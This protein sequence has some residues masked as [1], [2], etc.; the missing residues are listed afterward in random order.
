M[1][2]TIGRLADQV[3]G[4][5]VGQSDLI[6]TGARSLEQ[7]GPGDISFVENE[8]H[9]GRLAH[10]RASAVVVSPDLYVG[11]RTAIRVADPLTAFVQIAQGFLPRFN[12]P[13]GIDPRAFVHPS[14]QVHA[15]STI[16]AF[17]SIGPNAVIGK[18]CV[19]H[20]GVSVGAHSRVGD[21]VILFSNVVLYDRTVVGDRVVIHANSVIGA[22]GFGYRFQ[23]GRHVKVP[24]MGHV[25]IGNDVEIGA[26]STIDRGTFDPTFIGEGTKIDNLV[27]VA[28]NC[29]IGRHNLLISQVGIA[30]SCRTGDYVIVAGQAG[31]ADHV[32]VGDGVIVG[33][34][35][36]VFRD[37]GSGEKVLG[38]PAIS[39]RTQKRIFVC[40]DKLPEVCRDVKRIKESLGLNGRPRPP[41]GP[42]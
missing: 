41:R 29:R 31:L 9:S 37:V 16:Q 38:S 24:Q 7:A 32:T 15:S 17:A 33:S 42:E 36:G 22:D 30:G 21:E 12:Q 11:E 27:M 13:P 1:E 25:E 28:H 40:L 5:V 6:I 35:A 26:G 3:G 8:R 4:Q 19:I 14:S 20:S 18:E 10:T 34:Q 2:I 23:G 39:E